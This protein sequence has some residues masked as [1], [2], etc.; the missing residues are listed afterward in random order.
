[1]NCKL[2]AGPFARGS[3]GT[4]E[5]RTDLACKY[6]ASNRTYRGRCVVGEIELVGVGKV[7]EL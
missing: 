2:R 1:L 6:H 7:L 4:I 3:D 5:E